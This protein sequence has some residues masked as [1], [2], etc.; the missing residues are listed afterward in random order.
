MR[1]SPNQ[2]GRGSFGALGKSLLP[3]VVILNDQSAGSISAEPL[4][5][6]HGQQ[7][8]E[9]KAAGTLNRL[10]G[11]LEVGDGLGVIDAGIWQ[12]ECADG[13]V[14]ANTAVLGEDDLVK[15]RGHSDGGRRANHLVLDVPLV[16]DGVLLGQIQRSRDDA[17]RGISLGQT[18]AEV[19]KVRP[20]VAV[21]A[22]ANLRAHV[23]EVE[24][25]VHGG[26]RPLCVCGGHLVSS[27]IAAAEVVLEQGA[28]L[29][30]HAVVL[31]EQAV[32]AV[33]AARGQRL[34]CD[35]LD[36]PVGVAR[37]AV[38]ARDEGGAGRDVGDGAWEAIFEEAAWVDGRCAWDW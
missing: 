15:V 34:G 20:V 10:E 23:A 22:L 14:A 17:H 25:L 37:A 33:T 9:F 28:E 2:L 16:V 26:L 13:D 4:P 3:I 30:G 29:G 27:I 7:V 35:V 5:A 36:D 11:H 8:R 24:R 12:N 1:R 18:T 21:E 32:L 6:L 19:L 38:V 31:E